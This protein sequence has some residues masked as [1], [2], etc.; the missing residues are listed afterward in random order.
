MEVRNDRRE[1]YFLEDKI[2]HDIETKSRHTREINF[3]RIKRNKNKKINKTSKKKGR[4][5]YK[6]KKANTESVNEVRK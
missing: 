4:K 1:F 2:D 5:I 6:D 3:E